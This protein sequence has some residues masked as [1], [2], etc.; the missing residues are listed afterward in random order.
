[1]TAGIVDTVRCPACGTL[2]STLP[3]SQGESEW[4]QWWKNRVPQARQEHRLGNREADII[5]HDGTV[6]EVQHGSLSEDEITARERHYGSMRWIFDARRPYAEGRLQLFPQ[7]PT[8]F[9]WRFPRT[10]IRACR[11]T[12]YLDL[13]TVRE[14]GLHMLLTAPGLALARGEGVGGLITATAMHNWLAH[15]TP[16]TGWSP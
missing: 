13:G 14:I 3:L 12:I 16:L 15:G 10:T 5:A 9:R 6:V 8:P 1:M 4:H 7:S 11:R 2:F